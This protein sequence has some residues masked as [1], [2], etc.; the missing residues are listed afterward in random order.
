[1]KKFLRDKFRSVK[2]LYQTQDGKITDDIK[3]AGSDSF[4]A[5]LVAGFDRHSSV[6]HEIYTPP[7]PISFNPKDPT[8][9]QRAFELRS[10]F[11]GLSSQPNVYGDGFEVLQYANSIASHLYTRL[12][13]VDS[14]DKD[15]NSSNSQSS[16]TDNNG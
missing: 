6:P 4:G 1:M 12:K 13:R 2:P 3:E 16:N 7:K 5:I 14:H 10:A 15:N 9:R 11:D 8:A